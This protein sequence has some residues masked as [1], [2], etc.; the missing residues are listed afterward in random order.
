MSAITLIIVV[1]VLWQK[2]VRP[3]VEGYREAKPQ[4]PSTKKKVEYT[5]YEEVQ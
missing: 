3:A 5:D 4:A 1:L 2:L